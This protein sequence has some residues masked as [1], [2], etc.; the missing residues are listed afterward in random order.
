MPLKLHAIE[1]WSR[2]RLVSELGSARFYFDPP[3]FTLYVSYSF[4]PSFFCPNCLL[5]N[6]NKG[7]PLITIERAIHGSDFTLPEANYLSYPVYPS[8]TL[9]EIRKTIELEQLTYL[10]ILTGLFSQIEE[11][12]PT[13]TGLRCPAPEAYNSFYESSLQSFLSSLLLSSPKTLLSA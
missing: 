8:L 1:D 9:F 4:K 7:I 6:I 2:K 5:I 10:D 12:P 3:W 13:E 11:K